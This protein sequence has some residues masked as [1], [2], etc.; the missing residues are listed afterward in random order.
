M[1]D[2]M[3]RDERFEHGKGV[4]YKKWRNPSTMKYIRT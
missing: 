3:K 2:A 4:K 1:T